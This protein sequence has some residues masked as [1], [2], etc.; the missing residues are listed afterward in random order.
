MKRIVWQKRHYRYFSTIFFLLMIVFLLQGCAF[1]QMDL[2]TDHTDPLKEFTLSGKGKE[3]ILLLPVR[4]AIV[5]TPKDGFMKKEPSLVQEVVSQLDKAKKDEMIKAVLIKVD[6][7]GGSATAS[8]VLYQEILSF[9]QETGKKVVVSMMDVAASGGYYISLPADRIMAHPT[10]L[11]GSVGTIFLFPKLEGLMGKVGIG[12]NVLKSGPNKD[13]GSPLREITEKE[14]AFFQEMIDYFTQKFVDRVK[15]HRKPEDEA[16]STITTARVFTAEEAR[17]LGL[18]DEIG[19]LTDAVET[20]KKIAGVKKDA[21]LVVYRR[22]EYPDDNVYNTF[23]T[24]AAVGPALIRVPV[25][26]NLPPLRQGMYHLWLP[27]YSN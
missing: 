13:M 27:G 14:K 5:D 8:D 17:A 20:A 23:T 19:Y 10:T 12:V 2:F 24:R 11:T 21:K 6:S 18:V 4:G 25:L 16:L 15:K 9:R 1:N 7:P 3:K 26:D 22:Q